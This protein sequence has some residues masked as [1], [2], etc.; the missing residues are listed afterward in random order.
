MSI[1]AFI[2]PGSPMSSPD[3]SK[4]ARGWLRR[5][6]LAL[7]TLAA[8]YVGTAFALSR[9][10]DPEELAGWLEPRLETALNRDV[11]VGGVEVGFFPLAVRLQALDVS[12]P[13]GL[14]QE[15]AHIGSLELRV[16][17]LPLLRRE[18]QVSRL[19]VEELRADLRVSAEGQSNFGDF[20]TRPL[21]EANPESAGYEGG[22]PDEGAGEG[23]AVEGDAARGPFS[24]NLQ[25]ILTLART[26]RLIDEDLAFA[27]CLRADA[28]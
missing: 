15:L 19:V 10:L 6:A 25:G 1:V 14:A 20:S 18:I 28:E 24:L 21:A 9:F 22:R 4:T 23:A 16:K 7:A 17:I 8:L 27:W 3:S 12:D 2:H 13:T 5:S 11:T 26:P